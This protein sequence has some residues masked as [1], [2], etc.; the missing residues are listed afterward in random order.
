MARKK[1]KRKQKQPRDLITLGMLLTRKGGPMKDRRAPR[2]GA[3]N[4]HRELM[5]E[6]SDGS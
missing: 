6:C 5:K 1:S 4:D 3:K 2:G